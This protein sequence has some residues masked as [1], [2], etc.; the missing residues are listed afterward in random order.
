VKFG[1]FDQNDR[2]DGDVAEQYRNRLE[3]AG[4]YERLGFFCYHMSEHHGTPLSTTP[5]PSVFLAALSQRTKTLRFGP[6]VYLLPGYNPLRLAE[7]ICMLDNL[8]NGRFQFGVGRGAS[9]HEMGYLGVSADTMAEKYEEA[10]EILRK[11]LADGVLNHQGKYWQYD[12]VELSIRPVQ[13]PHPPIWVAVGS[14][15]SATAPAR[16]GNNIV[17]GGP[18]ERARG[19][20]S[21]YLSERH[22]AGLP[23]DHCPLM[24]FNRYIL[25]AD[26]DEEALA[27]GRKAWSRFYSGFIKLWNRHGGQPK[28]RV[29]E[30]FDDLV[31]SGQMA[32]GAP[33]TVL[34]RLRGQIALSGANFLSGSF[35]FGDIPYPTI[36]RSVE[37]FAEAVM[38]ALRSA[39]AEAH[40]KLLEAA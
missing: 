4:L 34:E 27:V 8:S 25:I 15:E 31:A 36:Q 20:F 13:L 23:A 38:P 19:V 1:I 18:T 21:H 22:A 26:S 24:G 40:A 33:E 30:S 14:A 9:P 29:P 12:H 6:L 3:L 16:N 37:L 11:G 17:F 28:A 2:G 10:L 39:S 35:A 7:E 5:S 32:V